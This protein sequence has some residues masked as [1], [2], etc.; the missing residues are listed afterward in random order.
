MSCEHEEEFKKLKI[1]FFS[2]VAFIVIAIGGGFFLYKNSL[3]LETI[4]VVDKKE[5]WEKICE[6]DDCLESR[7]F[8]IHTEDEILVTEEHI[9][10][11]FRRGEKAEVFIQGW[12]FFTRRRK[13]IEN[14]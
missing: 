2:F 4:N 9:Y 11:T 10:K 14:L 8:Q 5:V 7:E 13:I 3:V 6:S 12:T 1:I